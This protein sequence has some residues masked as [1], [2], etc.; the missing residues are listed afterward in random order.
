MNPNNTAALKL[1]LRTAFNASVPTARKP[2]PVFGRSIEDGR[3]D[4]GKAGAWVRVEHPELVHFEVRAVPTHRDGQAP[5]HHELRD[6]S[7]DR[8][9]SEGNLGTLD[10]LASRF[11]RQLRSNLIPTAGY[12]LPERGP[13][14]EAPGRPRTTGGKQ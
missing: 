7:R 12:I 1:A 10:S 9:L 13:V 14:C 3:W 11:A 8:V 2:G 5:F 6:V 4:Y